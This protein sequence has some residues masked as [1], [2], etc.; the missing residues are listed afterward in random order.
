[1]AVLEDQ[2]GDAER[3]AGGEQVGEHA[4]GGDERRLQRD[5][6]QQEAE[7]EHDADHERRLAPRAA[8]R[9]RGSRP[10]RRR[11]ARPAG[12]V[13]A[14]PVDRR[15][16]G[17]ARRVGVRDRLHQRVRRPR[18]AA[19]ACTCAMPGSACAIAVTRCASR[20]RARRSAAAPGAPGPKAAGPGCSRRASC[21]R[22]GTTLIDGMPSSGRGPAAA[23][24][25]RT[26]SASDAVEQRA[27]P[28]PLAPA[29]RS[30]ASGARRSATHGSASLS[31]RG[32]SLA[33]H[34]RQQRQRRREDEDDRDHDP[35]RHRA[36]GGARH[37]HHRATAR[38]ARSRRRR[39][40]PCRRCP[41]S[42]RRRPRRAALEPKSAPRKRMTMN[43]A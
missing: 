28:E 34:R 6:Q 12:S 41:S 22:S 21:R 35:E 30:A 40:P 5:E 1:M 8:A 31:T 36:E 7:G 15:A 2:P 27:A 16:D 23:S 25:S 4:D 11:R 37:E 17:R 19:P 3:G 10:P 32:P 42:R 38:S 14:Q 24:A 26:T 18:R 33:E 43:S 20:W 39:A 13:G 29:R 9:G